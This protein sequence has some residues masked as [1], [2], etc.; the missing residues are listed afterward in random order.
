MVLSP[1]IPVSS[2]TIYSHFL[3][4]HRE[5]CSSPRLS[6]ERQCL[7]IS[8]GLKAGTSFL[9][10]HRHWW[11]N[12]LKHG[13]VRTQWHVARIHG[14]CVRKSC[15]QSDSRRSE[16]KKK[17]KWEKDEDKC[18][19]NKNKKQ[20]WA[21]DYVCVRVCMSTCLCRYSCQQVSWTDEAG[22]LTLRL[23]LTM[24]DLMPVLYTRSKR[25]L[26]LARNLG[27]ER[28][29]LSPCGDTPFP[30]GSHYKTGPTLSHLLSYS[31]P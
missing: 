1:P 14:Q 19:N 22:R 15:I 6:P 11:Q 3:R 17:K 23:T 29:T 5:V 13:R 10:K 26:G 31:N 28:C 21:N 4:H 7:R 2:N 24:S 16:K 27:A 20:I 18:G 12:G 25:G 9:Y 30:A 8:G